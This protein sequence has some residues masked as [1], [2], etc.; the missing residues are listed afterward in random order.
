MGGLAPRRRGS[1]IAFAPPAE[2]AGFLNMNNRILA[3]LSAIGVLWLL[4]V[5]LPRSAGVEN[6]ADYYA[7]PVRKGVDLSVVKERNR[8]SLKAAPHWMDSDQVYRGALFL[9]GLPESV[10]HLIDKDVGPT[11]TI[12]DLLGFLLTRLEKKPRYLEIGVRRS[13]SLAPLL[14]PGC[15]TTSVSLL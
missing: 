15:V 3:L 9:Y 5:A 2:E 10:R 12:P 11:T 6:P 8:L 14:P 4:Y 1:S 13:R 7:A